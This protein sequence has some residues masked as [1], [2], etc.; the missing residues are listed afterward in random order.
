MAKFLKNITLFSFI[1]TLLAGCGLGAT[2]VSG[3]ASVADGLYVVL[4]DH[5]LNLVAESTTSAA[6]LLFGDSG[7]KTIT[8]FNASFSVVNQNES[9]IESSI[10][11]VTT[12]PAN[13]SMN[14][15]S[16]NNVSCSIIVQDNESTL[17]ESAQ[18]II[19]ASVTSAATGVVTQLIP[20]NLTVAPNSAESFE[21][22]VINITPTSGSLSVLGSYVGLLSLDNSRNVSSV[23]ITVTNNQ[24]AVTVCNL[25]TESNTCPI[26][27]IEPAN[28]SGTE[29]YTATAS[30]YTTAIATF[31]ISG[32]SN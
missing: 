32:S 3:G 2:T 27:S 22:G 6:I 7:S 4:S 19:K 15:L 23:G 9:P 14:I 1:S 5:S 17:T 26:I 13:C 25:S 18:Y 8:N 30:G 31:T 29:T 21:S 11:S 16:S 10:V 20:I 24:G 12:V 28:W